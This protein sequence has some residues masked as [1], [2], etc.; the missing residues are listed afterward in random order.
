LD[1]IPGYPTYPPSTLRNRIGDL[2]IELLRK[3][4]DGLRYSDL[5]RQVMEADAS[6]KLSTVGGYISELTEAYPGR[7]YRPSRGL[8][9]LYGAPIPEDS[10]ERLYV[11]PAALPPPLERPARPAAPSFDQPHQQEPARVYQPDQTAPS[12]PASPRQLVREYAGTALGAI[13]VIAI[14]LMIGARMGLVVLAGR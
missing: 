2:A 5:V 7:V 1:E 10:V 14:S 6:L 12:V 3:N 4:P 9:R 13:L 11:A 8:F